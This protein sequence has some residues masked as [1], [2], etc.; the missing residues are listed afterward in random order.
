MSLNRITPKEGMFMRF[1]F[2]FI[3]FGLLFYALY[4]FFPDAF[5]KLASWAG[6][7]VAFIKSG[8]DQLTNAHSSMP[9]KS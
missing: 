7:V 6:D 5:A 4:L 9:S 3:F 2:N 8:I 1:I